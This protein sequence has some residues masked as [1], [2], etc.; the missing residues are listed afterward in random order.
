MDTSVKKIRPSNL[1]LSQV[2]DNLAEAIQNL[3]DLVNSPNSPQMEL[4][5]LLQQL[6]GPGTPKTVQ[7]PAL[8]IHGDPSNSGMDVV[9][10]GDVATSTAAAVSAQV[11]ITGAVNINGAISTAGTVNIGGTTTIRGHV[12]IFPSGSNGVIITPPVAGPAFYVT[13]IAGTVA[14]FLVNDTGDSQTQ[15]NFTGYKT[16]TG[17]NVVSNAGFKTVV[18]AGTHW[19]SAYGANG[20][21]PIQQPVVNGNGGG[22]GTTPFLMKWSH[23]GSVVGASLNQA[24]PLVGTNYL[25]I[26]K[27]GSLVYTW[28]C[29][30]GGNNATFWGSFAKGAI[31]FAAGDT[32]TVNHYVSVSGNTQVTVYLTLE[33]AA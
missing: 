11:G 31:P 10:I 28:T 1:E 19:N 15:G 33:M 20:I 5:P 26:L 9:T 21:N 25:Q 32:M 14:N 13:N 12:N 30:T 6:R 2:Q 3:L 16:I 22:L 18:H 4:S 27:N 29:G 24:G 23:A 7:T 8:R 17:T